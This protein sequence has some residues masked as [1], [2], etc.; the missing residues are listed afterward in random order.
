MKILAA[1]LFLIVGLTSSSSFAQIRTE[2]TKTERDSSTGKVTTTTYVE[3]RKEED[4]TPRHNVITINPL[5]FFLFYNLNYYHSIGSS[6]AIGGGAQL[7]T[8]SGLDGYGVNLEFRFYP[9]GR[10][11]RGFYIAPNISYNHFGSD[12]ET[13]T[14]TSI[15]A[16]VGWQWFP[17]DDFAIGLGIGLDH[18]FLSGSGDVFGSYD[19]NVPALRFDIGYGWK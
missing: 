16:L 18:Y 15:G 9:S 17:G 10:S 12:G 8:L 19:G 6:M 4:I 14:A 5:K 1:I 13:A 11:L 7:P 2:G 3:E